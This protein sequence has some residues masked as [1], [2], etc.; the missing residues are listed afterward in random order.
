MPSSTLCKLNALHASAE[1]GIARSYQQSG[2]APQAR[3]H[4][5]RFQHITQNKLARPSGWLTGIRA[6]IRW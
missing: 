2:D 3:E 6:N 4:L 5:L 1:F